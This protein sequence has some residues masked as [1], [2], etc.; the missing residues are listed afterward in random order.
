M[1][2]KYPGRHKEPLETEMAQSSNARAFDMDDD[3][4][5][6]VEETQSVESGCPVCGAE[7]LAFYSDRHGSYEFCK[8][9]G[10]SEDDDNGGGAGGRGGRRGRDDEDE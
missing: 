10:W 7:D 6:E 2:G 8:E 5:D 1:A 3:F 9:C 4:E